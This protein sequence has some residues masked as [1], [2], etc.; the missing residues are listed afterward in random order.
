MQIEITVSENPGSS[1]DIF[2]FDCDEYGKL[3]GKK[4]PVEEDIG[5]LETIMCAITSKMV[6]IINDQRKK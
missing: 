6:E 2:I 1:N 3:T 5:T 4:Y